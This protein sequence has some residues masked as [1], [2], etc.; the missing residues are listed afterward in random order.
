MRNLILGMAC[1]GLFTLQNPLLAEDA[2][3]A[4]SDAA[5]TKASPSHVLDEGY[6][7]GMFTQD[8]DAA[9]KY[10]KEN[11]L[12]VLITPTELGPTRWG[13]SSDLS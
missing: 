11:K 9:L 7:A 12:P 3:D 6:Q 5:P 2:K 4:G 13:A 8:Y 10:A 1:L